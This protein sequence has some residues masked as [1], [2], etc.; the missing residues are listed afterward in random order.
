MI[1]QIVGATG[2]S[3]NGDY[4]TLTTADPIVVE[5]AELA[6]TTSSY[7]LPANRY[8]LLTAAMVSQTATVPF[9]AVGTATNAE[10]MFTG[11]NFGIALGSLGVDKFPAGQV[12]FYISAKCDAI[13]TD[14]LNTIRVTL[15]KYSGGAST[16]ICDGYTAPIWSTG[17]ATYVVVVNVAAD[18]P[19]G[20]TD[21]LY[22]APYFKTTS[23][24]QQICRLE[25]GSPWITRIQ[26]TFQLGRSSSLH[27]D[28]YGRNTANNHFGVGTATTVSGI[29]PVPTKT[30]MVIT[31]S[32]NPF[33]TGM[34]MEGLESGVPVELTFLQDCHL[35]EEDGTLASGVARFL[36]SHMDGS[37][38][39]EIDIAA[40]GRVGLRFFATELPQSPCFQLKWGPIS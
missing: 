40:G 38:P 17:L 29:V 1:V 4:F 23:A 21:I 10:V 16:T 20:P 7:Y 26:T 18:V 2:V 19:L 36:S 34:H 39:D 12:T 31:I 13:P 5:T 9:E 27:D 32:G 35:I 11:D 33:L 30:T 37:T 15:F 3:H 28:L 25:T 6:F 14:G 8:M 24:I 22:F